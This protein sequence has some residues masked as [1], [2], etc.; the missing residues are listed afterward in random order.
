MPEILTGVRTHLIEVKYSGDAKFLPSSSRKEVQVTGPATTLNLVAPAIAVPGAPVTLTATIRSEGGDS[1]WANCIS[2]RKHE[3]GDCSPERCG[4]C[5]SDRQHVRDRRS[6]SDGIFCR[7]REFRRQHISAGNHDSHFKGLLAGRGSNGCNSSGRPIRSVQSYGHA[8]RGIRKCV[9]FSCPVLTGITCSF[10][11]PM[12]TP[13]AG[14]ATTMLTV[15]TSA[16]VTRYGQASGTTGSGFLLA[17]LGLIGALALFIGKTRGIHIPFL[18]VAAGALSVLALAITLVSC[19]GYTTSGQ[20]N[21]G[22]ASIVVTAQ[23]RE[24]FPFDEHQRD[25]AVDASRA[26]F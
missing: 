6:F 12:V 10:N 14:A 8:R 21:R 3:F 23:S 2:R 17:T 5:D 26:F 9:T 4:R 19:G 24:Q 25:G 20:T 1:H 13:N 11:P 18:K 15:T 7:R 22:T 16:G